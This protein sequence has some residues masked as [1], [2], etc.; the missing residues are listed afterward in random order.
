[1]HLLGGR[2]AGENR[3]RPCKLSTP[4]TTPHC[5]RGIGGQRSRFPP[6]WRLNA[7]PRQPCYSGR[8]RASG[9][10]FVLAMILVLP[11][12][13]GKS[14]EKQVRSQVRELADADWD[15]ERITISEFKPMGEF[16]TAEI[17]L[18]LPVKLR[19][20][21][22]HWRIEEIRLD[23]RR[24]ERVDLILQALQ[25]E[26]ISRTRRDL[27]QIAEAYR[28]WVQDDGSFEIPETYPELVDR[29]APRYLDRVIRLDAWDTPYRLDD[30]EG[31][32]VVSAGPDRKFGTGDDLK[33]RLE[34]SASGGQRPLPREES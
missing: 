9:W 28:R 32:W 34:A 7:A 3:Y 16:A 14:L 18:R 19:R 10:L 15:N 2:A 22:G 13:C 25:A 6:P 11:A 17:A 33:R 27:D 23:D 8:V 31:L 21:D 1:M 30:D 29:L 12:G 24:W 5:G 26:R 20:A 4:K